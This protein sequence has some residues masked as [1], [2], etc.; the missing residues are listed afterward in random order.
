MAGGGHG[1]R[2]V[3]KASMNEKE[4]PAGQ[5]TA[6]KRMTLASK[7][8][9]SCHICCC[10]WPFHLACGILVPRLGSDPCPLQWKCRILTTGLS[11]KSHGSYWFDAVAPS[12]W[13][14]TG[15]PPP[16]LSSTHK[17]AELRREH[18]PKSQAFEQ[19]HHKQYLPNL[20]VAH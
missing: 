4:W 5:Q 15:E 6:G 2:Q 12:D 19:Y 18:I 13:D 8:S 11:G 17:A 7:D 1:I 20:L 16:A 3:P 14:D 10:F 9:V